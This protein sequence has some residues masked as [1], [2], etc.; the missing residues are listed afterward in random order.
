MK[1]TWTL[2]ELYQTS[3]SQIPNEPGVYFIVAPSGMQIEF[4]PIAENTSAPCYEVEKLWTKYDA[5]QNK[6]VLYIGKASGKKGL[7]QRIRQYMKYGWKE[8]VN[9]KGGRAIWQIEGAEN[10]LLRY[11]VYTDADAR[12]HQLLCEFVEQN[13]TLPLANWKK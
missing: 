11:E 13:G 12:E 5:C 4:H 9:H 7:R 2:K 6:E 10:L 3:C 1:E 8:A